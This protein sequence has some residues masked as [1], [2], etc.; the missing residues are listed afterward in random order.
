MNNNITEGN[1]KDMSGISNDRKFT[2]FKIGERVIG[3]NI[4][5]DFTANFSRRRA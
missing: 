2:K 4:S 3:E 1:G 5:G